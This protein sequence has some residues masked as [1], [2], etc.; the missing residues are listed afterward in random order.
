MQRAVT[1][2]LPRGFRSDE[3]SGASGSPATL[4]LQDGT[5][6][7]TNRSM[8]AFTS[9]LIEATS[10]APAVGMVGLVVNAGAQEFD[11]LLL[12]Q[13]DGPPGQP[14]VGS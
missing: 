5:S 14:G 7:R 13:V 3:R 11:G 1:V 9:T 12:H 10:V 2:E 8:A 6:R 4:A